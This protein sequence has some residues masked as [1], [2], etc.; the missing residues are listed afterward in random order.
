MKFC[1]LLS[2]ILL[3]LNHLF[4]EYN[5]CLYHIEKIKQAVLEKRFVSPLWK[6]A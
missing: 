1:L 5:I 3:I 2:R 4:E 6:G